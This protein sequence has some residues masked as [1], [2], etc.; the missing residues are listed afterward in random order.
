MGRQERAIAGVFSIDLQVF[1][2]DRGRF[3]EMF[4]DEWFP[5]RDWGKVQV[6]R[7]HSSANILRGLHYHHQQ[8]DYWHPLAGTIRVGLYD[9]RPQSPTHG[10]GESFNLSGQDFTG[11]FIPPGVAHGFYSVTDLTLI[12]VVDNYYDG[13]DELGVAWNDP[14]LGLDWGLAHGVEPVLSERDATNLPLQQIKKTDLP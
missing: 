7:S 4:R 12:Y 3:S 8:A 11:L 13:A 10:T 1:G 14:S 6:N 9:L 5:E 2:D